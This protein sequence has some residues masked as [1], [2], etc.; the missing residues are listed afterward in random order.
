[1]SLNEILILANSK[2][3]T[4]LYKIRG[5]LKTEKKLKNLGTSVRFLAPVTK[6]GDKGRNN[7]ADE[8]VEME[9][10]CEERAESAS[11]F[12]VDDDN[13]KVN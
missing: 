7:M 5:I 4:D 1:M 11:D 6:R 8:D 3:S 13:E 10:F 9:S 2:F 12:A